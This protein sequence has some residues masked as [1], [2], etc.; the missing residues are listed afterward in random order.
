MEEDDVTIEVDLTEPPAVKMDFDQVFGEGMREEQKERILKSLDI[1]CWRG[2]GKICEMLL[3]ALIL[4][5]VIKVAVY[6]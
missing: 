4:V 1:I 5:I 6:S 3:F 2:C